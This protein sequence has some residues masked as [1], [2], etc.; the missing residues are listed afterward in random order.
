M[1]GKQ[2]KILNFMCNQ[3]CHDAGFAADLSGDCGF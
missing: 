2:V 3:V 1:I